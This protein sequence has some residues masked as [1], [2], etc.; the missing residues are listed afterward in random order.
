MLL[1][2]I[3]LINKINVITNDDN[4]EHDYCV[5]IEWSKDNNLPVGYANLIMPYNKKMLEYW[6]TYTG[7]VTV[8]AQLIGKKNQKENNMLNPL[9]SSEVAKVLDRLKNEH[10]NYSFIGRIYRTKQIGQTIQVR[11]EDVGWK[12]LQKVPKQFRDSYI[13]GQSL[14][15]AFQAMCEFM[16]VDFAYS[17]ED[18]NKYKFSADG[19][20]IEKDG[21]IIEETPSLFEEWKNPT[22]NED[23]NMTQSLNDIGNEFEGVIDAKKN[24]QSKASDVASALNSQI[25]NSAQNT[26]NNVA[27]NL[28]DE[29]IEKYQEE[30][31][32]KI[33]DLFIGNTLYYSNVTDSILNYNSITIQPQSTASSNNVDMSVENDVNTPTED[34]TNTSTENNDKV[35]A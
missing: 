4:L 25:T 22:T 1:S 14:G 13:A 23:E 19:Y 8:N 20:S 30:F 33:K 2:S 12:F 27:N 31:D 15:D 10:Y 29:K 3:S 9:Q 17:I 24:T 26:A 7:M 21:T 16:G 32:K 11:L 34:G 28:Q 6:S 35:E 18:L 5:D